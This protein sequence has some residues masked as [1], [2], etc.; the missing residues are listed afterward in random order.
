MSYTD[1]QNFSV[2]LRQSLQLLDI[3]TVGKGHGYML[4]AVPDAIRLNGSVPRTLGIVTPRFA[5][6]RQR[7]S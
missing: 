6:Q 7:N 2:L 3:R 1:I 4:I 5:R